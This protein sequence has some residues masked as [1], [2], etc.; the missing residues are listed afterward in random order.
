M[1]PGSFKTPGGSQPS[2]IAA[3][4]AAAANVA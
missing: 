3:L 4:L 2:G 1:G